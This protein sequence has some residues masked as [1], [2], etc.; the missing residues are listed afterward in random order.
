MRDTEWGL[1]TAVLL[2][3]AA[4]VVAP[5]M[6]LAEFQLGPEEQVQAGGS[7]IAVPGYSVPSFAHWDDDGL[8]DLIVGEGSGLY[9][10]RVRVYLNTGSPSAPAFGGYFYAQSEGA[11]L[12]VPGGG[13]L[14]LYPRVVYWDGDGRKDLLVG[15]AD[16]RI[17]IFLN[18]ATDAEPEF[19]GGTFLTFGEPGAKVEMNVGYRAAPT[20]VD[21]DSDGVRDLAVGALDGKLHLFINEGT[22]SEPDFR[23]EQ[24]AQE[25]SSDLVVP[26]SRLSPQ[27]LDL[28]DDGKKDLLAGNTNGQVLLYSNVG[29]DAAP[30]FSGYA[31]VEADGVP[32]DLPGTPRSRIFVCDWTGDGLHDVLVGA[33]DGLVRLYQGFDPTAVAWAGGAEPPR[34][35][36]LGS[37]Y[38]NP[39]NP[40][41]TIPF[42][43]SGAQEV[44]ISVYDVEGRLLARLAEGLYGSGSQALSWR[45]LGPDGQVLPSGVY[46]LRMEGAG[47]RET[48]KLL[49]LR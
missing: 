46:F 20:A 36:L 18:T 45:G 12:T 19:D 39:F 21:W 13:C 33:G 17:R 25:N 31:P 42:V 11:D 2:A 3:A 32:I 1:W 24:F 8:P 27:V 16:G 22:T 40:Q 47:V 5:G 34:R 26:S 15:Q 38:P 37:P 28:D 9:T 23:V 35:A 48:T 49:L 4:I 10:G 29:T 14:G 43:L 44:S 7:N 41:V 6:A 30:V